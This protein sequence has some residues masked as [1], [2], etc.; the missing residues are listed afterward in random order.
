MKKVNYLFSAVFLIL[1]FSCSI[2]VICQSVYWLRNYYSTQYDEIMRKYMTRLYDPADTAA[3]PAYPDL[4]KNLDPKFPS[5]TKKYSNSR[6][7]HKVFKI[8][9][10]GQKDFEDQLVSAFPFRVIFSEISMAFR[11]SIGMKRPIEFSGHYLR[12]DGSLGIVPMPA[13]KTDLYPIENILSAGEAAKEVNARFHVVVRP[14]NI[15]DEKTEI[16]PGLRDDSDLLVDRRVRKLEQ[17]G[18]SVWDMRPQWNRRSDRSELFFRTDHHWNVYGALEAAAILASM[19]RNNYHLDYDLN[20]FDRSKFYTLRL[21]H[22]FLGSSGKSL[23][24]EYPGNSELD[25]MDIL[26][27]AY[28]TD[29]SLWNSRKFYDR[30][31][32]SIFLFDRHWKYDPYKTNPYAIWLD[33]DV[34]EVRIVNHQIPPDK[35]KKMLFIKDSYSISM[36]PYLALQTRE[37]IMID[38]RSRDSKKIQEIIRKEKPDFVFWIFTLTGL[39]TWN[40]A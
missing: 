8:M 5:K 38:P 29:F 24:A 30:G 4:K 15:L 28:K 9:L 20:G 10:P 7:V 34:A 12:P 6:I 39:L 13:D 33:G 25:D 35:G 14:D 19:L 31:D 3:D 36:L 37:I 1:L 22:I 16:Y 27:P 21:K 23:T 26:L 40:D 18:V 2:P 17:A 32:F 11:K